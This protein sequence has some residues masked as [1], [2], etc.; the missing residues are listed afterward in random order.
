MQGP[1]VCVHTCVCVLS[2]L[3][4]VQLCETLW[5]IAHQASLGMGLSRQGYWSGLPFHT[6]GAPFQGTCALLQGN[7]LLLLQDS[8]FR[9]C[10]D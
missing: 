2:R 9:M 1:R 4:H 6:E 7:N 5:T 3:S 10:G 8:L